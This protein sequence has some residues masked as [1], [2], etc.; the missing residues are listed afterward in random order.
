M[1]NNSTLLYLP[2]RYSKAAE[3]RHT[4]VNLQLTLS[5]E[6]LGNDLMFWHGTKKYY[7]PVIGGCPAGPY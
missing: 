4:P 1:K 7:F 3:S 5:R 6:R 2:A